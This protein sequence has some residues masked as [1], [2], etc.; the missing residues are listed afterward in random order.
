MDLTEQ[1]AKA[2][3]R[4][5]SGFE[6]QDAVQDCGPASERGR[7]FWKHYEKAAVAAIAAIDAYKSI[8]MVTPKEAT[9]V[10]V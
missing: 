9:T 1:V 5:L 2:I 3:G 7:P 10:R 6:N 8:E 4:A